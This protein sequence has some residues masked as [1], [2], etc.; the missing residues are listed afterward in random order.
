M[1]PFRTEFQKVT[2][3]FQKRVGILPGSDWE[4][5]LHQDPADLTITS[6]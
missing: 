6:K 2:L 5:K 4:T 3:G 1:Q